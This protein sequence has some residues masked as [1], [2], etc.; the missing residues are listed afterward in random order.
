VGEQRQASKRHGDRHQAQGEMKVLSSAA[1]AAWGRHMQHPTELAAV[2]AALLGLGFD[3]SPTGTRRGRSY[4]R[5]LQTTSCGDKDGNQRCAFCG[6]QVGPRHVMGCTAF[7]PDVAKTKLQVFRAA[8]THGR[9]GKCFELAEGTAPSG[10]DIR[11]WE[12]SDGQADTSEGGL[13]RRRGCLEAPGWGRDEVQS[14][15][16]KV[17]GQFVQLPAE[18]LTAT[19]NYSRHG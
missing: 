15:T 7:A 19:I 18:L 9:V 4:R 10:D 11:G 5:A 3:V 17:T 14:S 13:Q 2:V 1:R 16:G 12:A 8:G 6:K